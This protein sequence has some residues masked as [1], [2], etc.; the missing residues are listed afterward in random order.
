MMTLSEA[1]LTNAICLHV[2]ERR[3][4]KPENVE[5]VL[6]WEEETG[7]SAEITVEGRHIVW[8]EAN[9]VEAVQRYLWREY[10]MQVFRDGISFRLEDEILVD[11]QTAS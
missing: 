7:Y 3:G 8:I 10:H 2:A 9:M 1:E 6:V 5:V 11:V 4:V